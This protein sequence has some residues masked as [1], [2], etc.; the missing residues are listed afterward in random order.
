MTAGIY[1]SVWDG[2]NDSGNS[3]ASGLYII[4]LNAGNFSITRKMLL[5]K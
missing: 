1:N 3:V 5:I 2:T 4:R